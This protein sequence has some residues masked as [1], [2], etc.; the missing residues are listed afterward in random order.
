MASNDNLRIQKYAIL[1]NKTE[2]Q[3]IEW[4]QYFQNNWDELTAHLRDAT[5]LFITGRHGLEDGS[6]GPQDERVK[7]NQIEQVRKLHF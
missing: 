6:I 1:L 2:V 3:A 5:I 4:R 7:Q